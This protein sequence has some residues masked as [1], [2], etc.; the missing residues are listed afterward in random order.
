MKR[1][2]IDS[3]SLFDDIGL[4]FGVIRT[5]EAKNKLCHYVYLFEN[6][7]LNMFPMQ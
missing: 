5:Q 7:M 2:L 4:A 1:H 3:Y 6:Q